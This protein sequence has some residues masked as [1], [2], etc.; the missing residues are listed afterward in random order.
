MLITGI[1][2]IYNTDSQWWP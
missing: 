1:N 2:T